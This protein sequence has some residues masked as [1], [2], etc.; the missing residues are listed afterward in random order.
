M[1]KFPATPVY[2]TT[3]QTSMP[4]SPCAKLQESIIRLPPTPPDTFDKLDKAVEEDLI[5]SALHV[6]ATER[7]S[8][9]HL[10]QL[11]RSNAI[12]QQGFKTSVNSISQSVARGG[13]LVVCGVGKSGKIGLKVVASMNSFG[14]RS[15]F[16]H[17]TEALHGDLGMIGPV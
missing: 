4:L 11:Y 16:L 17:P 14:I 12:A 1:A 8:L 5:P 7:D 15:I 13:R 9:T 6:I 3:G 10:H 2:A